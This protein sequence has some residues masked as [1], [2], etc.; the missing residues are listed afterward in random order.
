MREIDMSCYYR[1]SEP[2]NYKRCL[3]GGE[4]AVLKISKDSKTVFC[5][6]CWGRIMRQLFPTYVEREA[7]E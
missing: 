3:C 7:K 6:D 2:H 4:P 5:W 1:I